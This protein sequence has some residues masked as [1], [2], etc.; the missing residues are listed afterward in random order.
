MRVLFC[1]GGTAGHITPALALAEEFK[2]RYRDLS[3]AF[4]GR[5][6]GNENNLITAQG[7]QLYEINV[8][9]FSRSLS[10]DNFKTVKA[11]FTAKR[12]ARKIIDEFLP[13]AVIGTG[14]YVSAPVISEAA[15]KR[16]FTVIHESNAS[17]GF[18]TKLLAGRCD[19]L[20]LGANIKTR[21]KNAK[22]VGIPVSERFGAISKASAR[23]RLGIPTD[24]KLIVSVGGSIG[25][26]KL[27]ECV[28]QMMKSFV[29]KSSEIYHIH[30]C[31]KRYYDELKS[32]FPE[33]CT[34]NRNAEIIPFID[35]MPLYLSAADLLICRCGAMT[36]A[37]AARSGCPTVMIPSPNVTGNHQMKNALEYQ[38]AGAGIIIEESNLTAEILQES[39]ETLFK[40]PGLLEEMG[41]R[42]ESFYSKNPKEAII[43]I[44]EANLN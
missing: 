1:G 32:S 26:K 9:G 4:V 40:T 10:I 44:I 35:D 36:L 15:K 42:A 41:K 13:D 31:G 6:G 5:K 39:T 23:K 29:S 27:N 17:V 33:L 20:L 18:A 7:Y 8:R 22:F 37:E 12:D 24:K 16:I 2:K 14:G 21:F 25:A 28:A 19:Y 43:G 34:G 38:N 3:I 11:Y 30:S